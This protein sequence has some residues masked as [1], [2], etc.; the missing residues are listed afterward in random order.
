MPLLP[1]ASSVDDFV[2]EPRVAARDVGAFNESSFDGVHPAFMTGQPQLAC[3]ASIGQTKSTLPYAGLLAMNGRVI[4]GVT[5]GCVFVSD[6]PRTK[7]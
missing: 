4:V 3:R 6:K 1:C 5:A 7:P 2:G